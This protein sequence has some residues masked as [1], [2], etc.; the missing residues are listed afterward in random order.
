MKN[1]FI[2]Q[3]RHDYLK[4]AAY[5]LLAGHIDESLQIIVKYAHDPQL[6]LFLA[7]LLEGDNSSSY[8]A[9]MDHMIAVAWNQHDL[10]LQATCYAAISDLRD[11]FACLF[12]I[13]DPVNFP[14]DAGLTCE[15]VAAAGRDFSIF[16]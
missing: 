4:A 11:M 15:C 8:H 5:F 12:S 1:A 16:S 14:V 10:L 6:A 13:S 7:V 3:S 2:L 9:I